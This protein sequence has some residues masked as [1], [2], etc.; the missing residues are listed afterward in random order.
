MTYQLASGAVLAAAAAAAL[1]DFQ[2]PEPRYRPRK[3]SGKN[4]DKVKAARKQR[5]KQRGK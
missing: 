1:G 3:P 5:R 4:R 2:A